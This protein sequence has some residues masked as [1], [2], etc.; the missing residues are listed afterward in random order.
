[1]IDIIKYLGHEITVSY[2]KNHPMSGHMG[3]CNIEKEAIHLSETLTASNRQ[4]TALHEL[5]HYISDDFSLD[6]SESA[7]CTLANVL[8]STLKDNKDIIDKI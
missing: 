5:I 6:L 8:Y 4:A 2:Y 7:V 1:M 3:M